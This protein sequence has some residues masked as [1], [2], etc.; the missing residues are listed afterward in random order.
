MSPRTLFLSKY[1]FDMGPKRDDNI[2]YC[3]NQGMCESERDTI[4]NFSDNRCKLGH[5]ITPTTVLPI[6]ETLSVSIRREQMSK[7][8]LIEE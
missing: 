7:L 6:A 5:L 4:N 8:H 2:I 3:L 1:A